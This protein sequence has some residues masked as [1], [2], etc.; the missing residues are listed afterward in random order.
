MIAFKTGDMFTSQADAYI[1]PVT[2]WGYEN[3]GITLR[4]EK[5][6]PMY[7]QEYR[8]L[9]DK[10]TIRPR[11]IHFMAL[12]LDCSHDD[13]ERPYY[14]ISLPIRS[15]IYGS[16]KIYK[17]DVLISMLRMLRNIKHEYHF[18]NSI[19]FPVLDYPELGLK[20]QSLKRHIISLVYCD[21]KIDFEIWG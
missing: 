5:E 10:G 3:T 1:C 19:A 15:I 6:Y 7:L 18:I 11:D 14:I 2:T 20:W 16:D 17:D 9:C 13:N 21:P 12:M 8:R 4:F